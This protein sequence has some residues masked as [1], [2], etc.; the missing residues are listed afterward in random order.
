[1]PHGLSSS[2]I[3]TLRL[4]GI[5]EEIVSGQLAQLHGPKFEVR[6]EE[7][8]TIGRGVVVLE[9]ALKEDA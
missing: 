4:L 2:D 9:G 1:M 3:K 7:A 8:C 5:T 6:I